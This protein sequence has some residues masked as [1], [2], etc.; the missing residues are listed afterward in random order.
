MSSSSTIL[1]RINAYV[2]DIFPRFVFL[3][4]TAGAIVFQPP[5]FANGN[6]KGLTARRLAPRVGEGN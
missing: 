1:I 6:R 5:D 3:I 4:I 2:R